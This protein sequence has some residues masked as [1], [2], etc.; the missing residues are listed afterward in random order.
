MFAV[1]AWTIV[2]IDPVSE[3]P[4]MIEIN[5]S[6]KQPDK[7]VKTLMVENGKWWKIR[8]VFFSK[9]LFY[10][11]ENICFH[12]FWFQWQ[13]FGCFL[14]YW[15]CI[16]RLFQSADL[17]LFPF[18]DNLPA[19]FR[20]QLVCFWPKGNLRPVLVS[21]RSLWGHQKSQNKLTAAPVLKQDDVKHTVCIYV[22]LC[23]QMPPPLHSTTYYKAKINSN[24]T[25]ACY[26][27]C[28]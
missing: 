17:Y 18:A 9:T 1:F 13:D 6:R 8:K 2:T 28:N 4:I 7:V 19:S 14:L 24:A 11:F 15:I 27:G 5:S 16:Y 25:A 10:G 20:N 21:H 12:C 23:F 22:L 3:K 26:R